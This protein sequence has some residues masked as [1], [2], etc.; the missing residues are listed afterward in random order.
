MKKVYRKPVYPS[1]IQGI[2]KKKMGML[3]KELT[4]PQKCDMIQAVEKGVV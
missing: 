3:E 2:M 1:T 4:F